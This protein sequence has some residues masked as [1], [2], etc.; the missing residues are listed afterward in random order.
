MASSHNQVIRVAVAS[1]DGQTIQPHFGKADR[2]LIYE[3]DGQNVR[4]TDIRKNNHSSIPD[5][6]RHFS[7]Y[8]AENIA[9]VSDC[10]VVLAAQIGPA[11]QLQLTD[12]GVMPFQVTGTVDTI[13]HV[14]SQNIARVLPERRVAET[15]A[16]A[17]S[18]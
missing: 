16:I 15:H 13:V 10:G 14:L 3:V 11:V 5:H 17:R 9:L 4:L 8:L 18:L 12:R 6:H 1:N 7:S 2:F